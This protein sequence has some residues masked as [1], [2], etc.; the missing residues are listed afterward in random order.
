MY[1]DVIISKIILFGS[2]FSVIYII[3]FVQPCVI[4]NGKKNKLQFF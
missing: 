2:K 3:V 4:F 1:F